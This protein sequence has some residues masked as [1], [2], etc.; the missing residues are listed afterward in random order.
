MKSKNILKLILILVSAVIMASCTGDFE[1]DIVKDSIAAI[2]VT[3]DGAVTSGFNPY[4]LI[5]YQG[6]TTPISITLTI[7]ETSKLKIKE[8]TKVIGGATSIIAG[9]LKSP[10]P[11]ATILSSYIASPIA[12]DGYTV[13][14][15]TTIAEFNSKVATAAKI[16]ATPAGGAAF[17]ERAF[18]FLLTMEDDSQIIP[19]QCRIRVTP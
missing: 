10:D 15:S 2:P 17:T 14:F 6:T 13:T 8:V 4:Y 12:V 3:Y 1:D 19:V 9:N 18:M 11:N 7:P 16:P 5:A